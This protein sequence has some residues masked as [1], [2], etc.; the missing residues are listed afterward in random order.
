MQQG[1]F[2]YLLKPLD[3]SQLR[4]VT[5]KAAAC[6][7]AQKRGIE[8]TPR[9]TVR[10]RGG[11]RQQPANARS[12]RPVEAHCARPTPAC[13]FKAHRHGQRARGPGDPPK[14]PPQ[15]QAI[16]GPQ[17]RRAEREHPGKRAV[18]PRPRCVHRRLDRSRRQVRIRPRRHAVSGRSRRHAHGDADQAAYA[19]WRTARSR[20]S[21]RTKRSMSTCGFFRPRIGISRS[22]SR[23]ARFAAIC[24]TA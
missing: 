24:I 18:R 22:R 20:E 3:L 9:R 19:C 12:D 4:A 11:H 16:R 2:N 5:E 1:A 10:L 17:L 7:A 14:Q 21:G 15:E 6:G 8:S 23:P 13:S